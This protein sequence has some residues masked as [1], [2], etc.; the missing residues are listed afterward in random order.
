MFVKYGKKDTRN[1]VFSH[2]FRFQIFYI[3]AHI[4]G[5]PKIEVV[6]LLLIF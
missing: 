5:V 6:A 1:K 3:T 4:Q 2:F